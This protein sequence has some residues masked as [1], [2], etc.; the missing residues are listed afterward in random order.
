MQKKLVLFGDLQLHTSYSADAY[1][2]GVR[3]TPD[4]AYRFAKGE[5]VEYLGSPV[6]R[7][8]PL[9]FIAVT[10][11]AENLGVFN[12]LEDPSTKISCTE[13]GRRFEKVMTAVRGENGF[14]DPK[15]IVDN[16]E[17]VDEINAIEADFFW[18][19][20]NMLPVELKTECEMAWRREIEAA[21]RHYEPG[22]FT[23]FIAY[24]WT[25]NPYGANLHRVVIFEGDSA[26]MPF[27]SFDSKYPEDL[28][29]WLNEV[30]S[31]GFEAIAIP[32]NSNA[33]A[34]LMYEWLDSTSQRIDAKYATAR[35]INEPVCE[36]SQ[37]KGASETHPELS[38]S[39]QFAD[40]KI[41]DFQAGRR[42]YLGRPDGSYL[43]SALGK[44]LLLH[45]KIGVN[46]YKLGFVGGS[47]LHGG[48]SVSSEM[49]YCGDGYLVNLG[50]GIPSRA[51]A[52]DI[53]QDR[54]FG[55]W[56][57]SGS[58]TGVWAERNTREAIYSSLRRRETFATSGTRVQI[59]LFGG[60][61]FRKEMLDGSQWVDAA[62]ANGV[63]MGGELGHPASG[64]LVPTFIAYAERDCNGANLDRMQIVKVWEENEVYLSRVFDVAWSGERKLDENTGK[65]P[66]VGDTVDRATGRYLNSVG[67]AVLQVMWCDPN[68]DPTRYSAYYLRVL[69][70]PTP[71]WSTL[72][73]AQN[74]LPLPDGVRAVEQQRAWSSPIWYSP[75]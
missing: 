18:G 72:V 74:G 2:G 12:G 45:R 66:D 7:R 39:D 27:S 42:R 22:R 26:P 19:R 5:A 40:F 37:S 8:E 29:S 69:E 51:R 54:A 4:E 31:Q 64:G 52:A 20:K 62:Y 15:R 9:D 10:D 25:S 41:F 57:T 33:S 61:C 35:Q 32:H 49:D 17:L 67:A 65:V 36:I 46:P 11:H 21:N 6:M 14:A 53:L 68:F 50:G 13:A 63:S 59:R 34:G 75:G 16:P 28:W 1:I 23:T 48:L 24:E 60:W 44:G 43:S 38:P 3:I 30:R 47:D 71:R 56:T 73:A 55:L 58:L 70:I